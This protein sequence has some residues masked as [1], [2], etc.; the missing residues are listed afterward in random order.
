MTQLLEQVKASGTTLLLIE[1]KM[2]MVMQ[3]CQHIVVLNFGEKIAEGSPQ[4]VQADPAVIEAYMGSE[5]D[6]NA[7]RDRP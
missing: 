5:T 6:D 4:K 7:A 2:A 3:L 1:H